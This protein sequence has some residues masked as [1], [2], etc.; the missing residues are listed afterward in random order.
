MNLR[1][2][3]PRT[4]YAFLARH[5]RPRPIQE[6]AVPWILQGCDVLLASA[7]ASGKTEAY[8]APLV[9]R[10]FDNVRGHVPILLV[11]SPTRALVNDLMRRLE[12]PLERC[13]VRLVRRTGDHPRP[14]E[15]GGVLLT[16]PES[17]DSLLCRH[18]RALGE[19]R[20]V[21]LDELHCLEG[22]PRGDQIRVLLE[23]LD[24]LSRPLGGLRCQ[25]LAATATMGRA[26]AVARLYLGPQARVARTEE[27]RAFQVRRAEART[28]REL[29]AAVEGVCREER[30]RKVLVF[31][32]SRA[33]AERLGKDLYGRPPFCT[34]VFVHH[35]SLSRQERERVEREFLRSPAGLCL[36]TPTLELGIDIGDVDLTVL[37]GPPPDVS[38]FLQRIGRGNRRDEIC[39]VLEIYRGPAQLR[40]FEHLQECAARGELH[41]A[42][43]PFR[44][45]VLVQQLFSLV[46][47]NPRRTITAEAAA[48]RLPRDVAERFP[49]E[50]LE[51]LLEHL[52]GR[53]WLE[54]SRGRY[55]PTPRLH[56]LFERGRVHGNLSDEAREGDRVEVVDEHT[57]RVVGQ[58]F[59]DAEGRL[60]GEITLAG[61]SRRLV[62]DRGRRVTARTTGEGE[63]RFR[64]RGTAAIS[65]GL[66]A[67]LARHLGV[68]PGV[69]PAASFEGLQVVGHFLGTARG[70]LLGSLMGKQGGANAFVA[71]TPGAW[72]GTWEAAD[73]R[74]L[75]ARRPYPLARDLGAGPWARLLPRQ[76]LVDELEELVGPQEMAR[77]LSER[78][79]APA[80]PDLAE[81]L[82]D[83]LPDPLKQ[84]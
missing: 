45:S 47:Q 31:T 11:V 79:P 74:R 12:K 41:S 22:T 80:S 38:S 8:A 70:R 35:G 52:E 14:P 29:A 34:R 37:V 17:L 40:R 42:E 67:D 63:P 75:L 33:E 4:W 66:A 84:R 82:V 83:L 7:T 43:I 21:V 6:E 71:W 5:P 53:G 64:S 68:P 10:H 19:V 3:L 73:I 57:G 56:R 69:A 46:F 50:R 25:R 28:P 44:P 30:L 36:A 60:P 81:V 32:P 61:R 20:A 9:E 62:S 16:T 26:E 54:R 59:R 23:R 48:G 15:G 55:I 13:G 39:R 1:C 51:E 78:R 65:H 77:R 49:A 72:R 76:W 27:Y 2:F 58:L 24:R 18:P